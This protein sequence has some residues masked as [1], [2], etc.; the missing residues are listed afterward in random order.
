MIGYLKELFLDHK[1]LIQYMIVGGTG[2]LVDN[3]ALYVL[4]EMFSTDV[5]VSKIMSAELAIATNFLIN[6][7]WTFREHGKDSILVRFL[8]SN[9]IRVFGVFVALVVLK[10]L[11]EGFGLHLVLANSIGIL[12]G[13]T[14]NYVLESIYT[15]KVHE[16]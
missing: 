13:F 14:S 16:S 5:T 1:R 9:V 2:V 6:D 10:I 4:V 7:F 12:I 11:Y 3:G 8:K 15:W